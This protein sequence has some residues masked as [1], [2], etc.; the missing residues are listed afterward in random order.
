MRYSLYDI[1]S[2]CIL[3]QTWTEN[4]EKSEENWDTNSCQKDRKMRNRAPQT[5]LRVYRYL[6]LNFTLFYTKKKFP[7]ELD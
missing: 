1:F 5:V 7:I 4:S 3:S 2:D 6:A